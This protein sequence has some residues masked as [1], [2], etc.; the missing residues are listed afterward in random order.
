MASWQKLIFSGSHAQVQSLNISTEPTDDSVDSSL[1]VEDGE[2]LFPNLPL[3][4]DT[5]L[6]A[7]SVMKSSPG[8]WLYVLNDIEVIPGCTNVNATNYNPLANTDDGTCTYSTSINLP[9]NPTYPSSDNDG[10]GTVAVSDV[11]QLLQVFG[12]SY[13]NPNFPAHLD[14][15]ND[16]II[17]V[18]EILDLLQDFGATFDN[19]DLIDTRPTITW[20][21]GNTTAWVDTNTS[22]PTFNT[23]TSASVNA[24]YQ[25]LGTDSASFWT[26]DVPNEM[27][28]YDNSIPKIS[29][30]VKAYIAQ[31]G[32][33][34]SIELFTYL[35]FDQ[36]T[37]DNA[38]YIPGYTITGGNSNYTTGSISGIYP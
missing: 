17:G 10:D 6:P 1:S 20:T 38:T 11:L 15:N 27:H 9:L 25:S 13:T 14:V 21:G 12:A 8:N 24:Y 5:S 22:S 30:N 33:S 36:T 34:A 2:V 32:Y 18:A 19:D 29:H 23:V 26:D 28:S 31:T 3:G 35:Y 7:G 16:G 4:F 37:G